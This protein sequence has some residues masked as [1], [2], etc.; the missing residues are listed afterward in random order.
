MKKITYILCGLFAAHMAHATEAAISQKK[1]RSKSLACFF[2]NPLAKQKKLEKLAQ[3]SPASS[4]I[5]AQ[6]RII[7]GGYVWLLNH[8]DREHPVEILESTQN[9]T[10]SFEDK[11]DQKSKSEELLNKH[12]ISSEFKNERSI[13]EFKIP[14]NEFYKGLLA[15]LI[16]ESIIDLPR[17]A[18]ELTVQTTFQKLQAYATLHDLEHLAAIC[19]ELPKIYKNEDELLAIEGTLRN[20]YIS[21]LSKSMPKDATKRSSLLAFPGLETDLI[22]EIEE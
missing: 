7:F 12:K 13:K 1:N 5:E 6:N 10:G 14:Q 2:T 3:V 17:D 21:P 15:E 20:K 8:R 18:G 11:L 19:E 16:S 4:T 22:E 9:T